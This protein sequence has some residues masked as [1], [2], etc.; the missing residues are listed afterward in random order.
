MMNR[1]L[2][3][4]KYL[5]GDWLSASAA[6]VLLYIFRKKILE[7]SKYGGDLP[8]QFDENFFY[9]LL[10]VPMFWV[11]LYIMAGQYSDIYRKHR[12]KEL[13]QT[14]LISVIGV[15]IIFFV[16]LLDDQIV[17]Y[18]NY[19]QS[20]LVLFG[21]HFG[22]T[23][24]VRLVLTTRTVKRIHAGKLGFNTIIVGGNERSLATYEE[25]AALKKSPGF[26]FLGFVRVNGKD[27]LLS[28]HLQMFGTYKDL[29]DLI[30]TKNI[31]EVILAVE[32]SDHKE[33]GTIMNLLEGEGVNIKIIPDVYDILSGSVKMTSIFGAPLIAINQE[34]MPAWQ[35]SIKRV[36]DIMASALAL[37]VLLPFLLV[38]AVL[39]KLSS[40]GPIFFTQERIG[41]YGEPFKIIKFRTM[42]ND[43]E[44]NG[45]QL[46]SAS[47]SRITPIGRFLRKTRIDEFPQFINVLKGEM[48]L[49]GPR[50]ERQF[51]IDQITKEAPHY[52]HLQKVRPGITSWGQVKYGYAENVAE[53]VQRLKYDLLYIENM[54]LAVDIKIL[55]YTILIVLRGEGK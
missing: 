38:I 15:V 51:Y 30:K 17:S 22:L 35:F 31:E 47:D 13:S 44:R 18:K 25:I 50:P 52:K 54:S 28:K 10:F 14:L 49:V 7:T 26:K 29:P 20:L 36:I 21:A 4:L 1:S 48:A 19:Y 34:I 27:T 12:L 45:P 6:W 2:Q 43:A 40:P 5:I 41:K 55:L 24:F 46:S 39:V 42:V 32:S 11:A 33:L 53:M 8:L 3:V 37:I 23:F 16:L 9:G